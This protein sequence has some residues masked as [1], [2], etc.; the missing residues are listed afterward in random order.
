M[1]DLYYGIVSG[2]SGFEAFFAQNCLNQK[3]TST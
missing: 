3:C 1:K 2:G